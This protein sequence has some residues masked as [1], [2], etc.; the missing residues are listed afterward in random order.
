MSWSTGRYGSGATRRG[1]EC[2][3]LLPWGEG[4]DEGRRGS[5]AQSL[6][7]RADARPLL[8]RTY[9]CR[10]VQGGTGAAPQGEMMNAGSFSHGEKGGMR[11]DAAAPR[12]V[13]SPAQTRDLSTRRGEECRLL[14]PWGEGWDEGRRGSAAQSL[15]ARADA[16]PLLYMDVRMPCSTW[17]YARAPLITPRVQRKP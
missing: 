6:L 3:L 1:D 15:L 7:T 14:L 16:R 4:W 8:Y 11:G 10:G 12:R 13:S 5:A 2:R 9:E 17:M